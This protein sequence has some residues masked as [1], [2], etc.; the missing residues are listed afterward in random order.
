MNFAEREASGTSRIL[1]ST[2]EVKKESIHLPRKSDIERTERDKKQKW[3][4]ID[5]KVASF[6]DKVLVE[7]KGNIERGGESR[8]D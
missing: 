2:Q 8:H 7:H 3:D 5:S 6:A 4:Y 1:H